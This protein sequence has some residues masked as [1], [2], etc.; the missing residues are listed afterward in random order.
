MTVTMITTTITTT[1]VESMNTLPD[2]LAPSAEASVRDGLAAAAPHLIWRALTIDDVEAL[3]RL[4]GQIEEH[5]DTPYRTSL[6][7]ATERFEADWHGTNENTLGGFDPDGALVA[8]GAVSIPGD[9]S[10]TRVNLEGGVRADHRNGGLG[11]AI[12]DWEICRARALVA[13]TGGPA[14]LVA[15]VEEGMDQSVHMLELR[16]FKPTRYF[17][18]LRRDLRL[19]F[20]DATL[21]RPLELLPWSAELDEQVRLAHNVTFSEHW[22][23]EPHSVETWSQGRTYFAPQW[24]FIVLDRTSDRSQV[25]GY[26]LSGRYE[27]DWPSLGWTE[28]YIDLL[29]VRPDWRGRG[30]ATALVTRAMRAYADDGLEYASLGVDTSEPHAVFG[31]YDK[32]RFEP[33]RGS[34]MYCVDL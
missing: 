10:T 9:A 25:V 18:E 21:N 26:L 17:T 23:S 4:L 32:L 3:H 29:G 5:D 30:I 7:E 33:T 31:L 2:S 11:S 12:L 20:P 6:E 22:V 15:H 24:S 14:R 13:Q 19:P 1:S 28:G 16:G 34:T 27:Q 8:F